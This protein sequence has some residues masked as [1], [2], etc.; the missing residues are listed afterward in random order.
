MIEIINKLTTTH[1][2]PDDVKEKYLQLHKFFEEF[3]TFRQGSRQKTSYWTEY[4]AGRSID[5]NTGYD[6]LETTSAVLDISKLNGEQA[7][8]LK[9]YGV[10]L[11]NKNL[12]ISGHCIH[13]LIKKEID[14]LFNISIFI[15]HINDEYNDMNVKI[16]LMEKNDRETL[17]KCRNA[18]DRR[19]FL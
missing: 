5:L 3:P 17:R 1:I 15:F 6:W 19:E 8:F 12:G 16:V 18:N 2:N 9:K 14:T 13:Y 10:G 7:G 4:T 11:Y